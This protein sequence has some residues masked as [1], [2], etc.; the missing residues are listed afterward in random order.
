MSRDKRKTNN[1]DF[2]AV[3]AVVS[4]MEEAAEEEENGAM[5]YQ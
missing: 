4:D 2:G 5:G 3:S 1:V